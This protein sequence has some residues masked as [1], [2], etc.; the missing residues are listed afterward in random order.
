[1]YVRDAD[2]ILC[3]LLCA[4][5]SGCQTGS[6]STAGSGKWEQNPEFIKA[7]DQLVRLLEGSAATQK[8]VKAGR[9]SGQTA[10][11]YIDTN[12]T[13]YRDVSVDTAGV[14][15][16]REEQTFHRLSETSDN[17]TYSANSESIYS[18]RIAMPQMQVC[19]GAPEPAP[20][21]GESSAHFRIETPIRPWLILVGA[22]QGTPVQET[23]L[24]SKTVK[25]GSAIF[26]FSSKERVEVFRQAW[27][28]L[29]AA[30]NAPR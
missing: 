27:N 18:K 21:F 7:R 19:K 23:K 25:S 20:V 5:F 6:T 14:L 11:S 16:F 8:G 1:M 12:T 3:L 9:V 10:Y 28:A 30:M 24:N 22:A 4:A 26:Y 13:L 29:I 17:H 15:C 2:F